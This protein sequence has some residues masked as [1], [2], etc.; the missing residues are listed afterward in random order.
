MKV[1]LVL[2]GTLITFDIIRRCSAV[3]STQR[4][5]DVAVSGED[6]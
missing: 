4:L 6:V 1:T 3:H 2:G 5:C